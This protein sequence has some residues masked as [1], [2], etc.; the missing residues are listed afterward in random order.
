MTLEIILNYIK[1]NNNNKNNQLIYFSF[2]SI[3]VL[4]NIK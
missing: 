2:K 1:N 3:E 4:L